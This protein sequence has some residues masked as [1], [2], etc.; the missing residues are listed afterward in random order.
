MLRGNVEG[1]AFTYASVPFPEDSC[2]CTQDCNPLPCTYACPAMCTQVI[3]VVVRDLD[4]DH[5][6]DAIAIDGLLRVYHALGPD[7]DFT[8]IAPYS[9]PTTPPGGSWT[10]A[11]LSVSGAP[12][13]PF[14][15]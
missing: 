7:F 4:G 9:I 11:T 6:L 14:K 10:G 13:Q 2:T 3:G 15:P 1:N 5:V 8:R 12:T